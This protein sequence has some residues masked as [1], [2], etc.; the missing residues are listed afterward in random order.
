MPKFTLVHEGWRIWP[1]IMV[2]LVFAITVVQT[3]IS[4]FEI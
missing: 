3:I 4:Q 1:T 2:V